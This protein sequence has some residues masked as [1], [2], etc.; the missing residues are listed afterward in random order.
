MNAGDESSAG[1]NGITEL[2]EGNHAAS[3]AGMAMFM[4]TLSVVTAC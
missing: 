2:A 1:A 3:G 4:T